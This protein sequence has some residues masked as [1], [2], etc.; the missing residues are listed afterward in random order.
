MPHAV[1]ADR[2][3]PINLPVCRLFFP[4][5]DRNPKPRRTL[6][7]AR[8]RTS[9]TP[10]EPSR[11]SSMPFSVRPTGRVRVR[12]WSRHDDIWSPYGILRLPALGYRTRT[13]SLSTAV[14]RYPYE[15]G[16]PHTCSRHP[17]VQLASAASLPTAGAQIS[18]S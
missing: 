3:P 15:Y 5:P 17:D 8:T 9:R 12:I 2:S 14:L 1:V 10:Q 11:T 4:V 7:S 13:R 16:Y 6:D 18:T